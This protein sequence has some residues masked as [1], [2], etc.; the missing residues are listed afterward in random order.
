[1]S[2]SLSFLL[3]F[4]WSG[5]V[6]SSLYQM[7]Q[8]SKVSRMSICVPKS[9]CVS[10]TQWHC[11]ILSCPQIVS[12]PL[13]TP[14]IYIESSNQIYKKL[15]FFKRPPS[16]VSSNTLSIWRF[17]EMGNRVLKKWFGILATCD[18]KY[19]SKPWKNLEDFDFSIM[20]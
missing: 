7:S 15:Y 6:F 12:G 13:K 1:M 11:H 9:K 3:S 20:L 5:H 10:L 4:C 2:L 16:L 18:I 14:C 8:R 17:R 19:F